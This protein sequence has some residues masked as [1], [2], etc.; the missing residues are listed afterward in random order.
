MAR[1]YRYDYHSR[2]F[3]HIAFRKTSGVS[4]LQVH[5]RECAEA[6]GEEDAS[7]V[8]QACQ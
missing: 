3:Y 2:F 5:P 1:C 4:A 8:F 6:G 7:R